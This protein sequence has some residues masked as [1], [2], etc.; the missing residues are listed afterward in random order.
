MMQGQLDTLVGQPDAPNLYNAL[1][2]L[3]VPLISMR[4]GL[5][6]ERLWISGTFPGLGKVVENLDAGNLSETELK[7]YA[8]RMEQI[9]EMRLGYA[10][11]IYL[12]W[13]IQQKHELAKQVLIDAGRPRAKVEAMPPLQVAMLHALLEYDAALDNLIMMEKRPYWEWTDPDSDVN[14]RYLQKRWLDYNTSAIPLAP[15]FVP[16]VKKV[17]SARVRME[18]KI[19]LL[20]TLEALRF[21]AANHDSQLPPSLAT[22]KEVPIPLDPVTGKDFAYQVNGDVAKLSAPPPGKEAPNR[23]NT[24]VYELAIRK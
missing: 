16:A 24:V 14:K 18:R 15:L 4:R 7:M 17:A 19:A 3:P 13:N 6:S 2:D 9:S 1:T 23:G 5:E 20:R 21:Y 12:G 11:R 10:E 22:I 8:K